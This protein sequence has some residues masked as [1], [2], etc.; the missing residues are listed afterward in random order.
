[1]PN[2]SY[3]PEKKQY[4]NLD[5]GHYVSHVQITKWAY[6]YADASGDGVASLASL[7]ANGGMGVGQWQAA[8]RQTVKTQYINQYIAGRGG[9]AQ[10]TQR[11][12]GA[13]GQMLRDQYG[14][15][16]GFAADVASGRLSE[17]Q[18]QSRAK[19]YVNAAHEAFERG[20]AEAFGMPALPAYPSD[21]QT[22]CLTNCR[23]NW[24]ITP[25]VKDGVT[26]G[27]NVKWWPAPAAKHC[28]D[29]LSNAGL[30]NPLFV[31]AGMTV[32]EARAWRA[33][34]Q[35]HMLAARGQ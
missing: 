28:G 33:E 5:T 4:R 10:M 34:Q 9:Y 24:I 6:A 1:M 7:V 20:R 35:D 29:C 26:V 30:W 23:C 2:W 32:P 17:G 21:G 12:W 31:P 18:I 15:L 25:V 11:D 14:Y 13:L 16:D 8:M 22:E 3:N 19:M 27:W